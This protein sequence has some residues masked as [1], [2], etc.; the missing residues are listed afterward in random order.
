MELLYI[1]RRAPDRSQVTATMTV[2][3]GESDKTGKLADCGENGS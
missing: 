2:T 3:I 1:F